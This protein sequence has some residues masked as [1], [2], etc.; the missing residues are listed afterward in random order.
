[1][2]KPCAISRGPLTMRPPL[3]N[4]GHSFTLLTPIGGTAGITLFDADGYA[5]PPLWR[6]TGC[7]GIVPHWALTE[8]YAT[9]LLGRWCPT[10]LRAL[11]PA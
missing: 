10:L 6:C 9:T 5:G 7:H 4:G 11:E 2:I 1:M 3:Y 8:G